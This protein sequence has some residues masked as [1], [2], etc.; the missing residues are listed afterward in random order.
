MKFIVRKSIILILLF[1]VTACQAD[2]SSSLVARMRIVDPIV[3]LDLDLSKVPELQI[4]KALSRGIGLTENGVYWLFA[5]YQ[6]SEKIYQIIVGLNPVYED[7]PDGKLLG[8]DSDSGS[9][10]IQ[11]VSSGK[12]K[13]VGAPDVVFDYIPENPIPD[14]ILKSLAGLYIE[15]LSM[16]LGGKDKLKMKLQKSSIDPDILAVKVRDSMLAQ[17]IL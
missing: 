1:V 14:D 10:V 8:F 13:I 6:E 12:Y 9:V 4:G 2:E 16:I 15:T 5:S 11:D 17:D 3:G 7:L